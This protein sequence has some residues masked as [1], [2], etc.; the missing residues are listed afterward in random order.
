MKKKILS[1]AL[2]AC[3]LFSC[4]ACDNS[5]EEYQNALSQEIAALTQQISTLTQQVSDLTTELQALQASQEQQ[6]AESEA[7]RQQL[8]KQTDAL[9]L[10]EKRLNNLMGVPIEYTAEAPVYLPRGE[11]FVYKSFTNH[12]DE[13]YVPFI[14]FKNYLQNEFSIQYPFTFYFLNPGDDEGGWESHHRR[15]YYAITSESVPENDILTSPMIYEELMIY[16]EILGDSTEFQYE[17]LD[18]NVVWSIYLQLCF[19]SLPQDIPKEFHPIYLNLIFGK[20]NNEVWDKYFNIYVNQICIGTCY[21]QTTAYV[22]QTW[23]E[24]YFYENLVRV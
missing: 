7:L 13:S 24:N 15:K 20:T 23:F 17:G 5:Q 21:F 1:L 19:T 10:M 2:A 16:D 14:E 3:T 12:I 6:T 9:T 22:S 4:V 18:G 8:Q 11:E